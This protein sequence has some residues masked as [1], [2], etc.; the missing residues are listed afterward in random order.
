MNA[1]TTMTEPVHV[2]L[3]TAEP[4]PVAECDVC[5]ALARERVAARRSGNLSRIS[6]INVEMRSH[7]AAGR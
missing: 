7:R 2:G 1:R 6:D 5:G 3:P 4:A